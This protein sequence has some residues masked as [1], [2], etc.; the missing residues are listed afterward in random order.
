MRKTACYDRNAFLSF[1]SLLQ[2]T[3]HQN[4][5]SRLICWSIRM[6][7]PRTCHNPTTPQPHLQRNVPEGFQH[8]ARLPSL[9]VACHARV[10]ILQVQIDR[11]SVLIR[12]SRIWS[13]WPS[14][15]QCKIDVTILQWECWISIPFPCRLLSHVVGGRQEIKLANDP[16]GFSCKSCFFWKNLECHL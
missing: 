13:I 5:L 9:R 6:V 11:S 15:N 10:S 3:I 7:F 8:L 12:Q 14:N 4:S 16:S 2:R 1:S